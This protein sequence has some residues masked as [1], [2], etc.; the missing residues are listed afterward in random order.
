[1]PSCIVRLDASVAEPR[2]DELLLGPLFKVGLRGTI[3][4]DSDARLK[5]L[6]IG[7]CYMPLIVS[8]FKAPYRRAIPAAEAIVGVFSNS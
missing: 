5:S 1:M 7:I 4:Y 3:I 8:Y 2:S 6:F